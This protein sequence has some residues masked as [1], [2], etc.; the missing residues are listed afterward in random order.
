MK[1]SLLSV[2][3][4]GL[5]SGALGCQSASHHRADVRDDSADRVTVA[6]VQREVHVGMSGA[7]VI[8]VLGSP[9]VVS[10][11]DQRREVWVYDK[12]A[13]EVVYS[14]S[15]G[16]V[17]ALIFGGGGGVFG[18]GMADASRRAGASSTRQRT[19]TVVIKFDRDKLVRDFAYRTS[20]F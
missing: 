1:Q 13:T 16:G 14:S 9:N 15:R 17:A 6:A 4:I 3:A 20:R 11:D 7:E 8:Q 5:L 19:L 2:L 10:T 12:V 18:G